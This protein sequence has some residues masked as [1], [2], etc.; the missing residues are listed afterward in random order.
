[1]NSNI[2]K[3]FLGIVAAVIVWTSSQVALA[4][5][6]EVIAVLKLLQASFR[7]KPCFWLSTPKRI[8]ES[9][10]VGW[11][12]QGKSKSLAYTLLLLRSE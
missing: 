9:N 10:D 7:E 6:S 11:T 12:G 3:C 5:E 4:Q 1:M 2:P 8:A